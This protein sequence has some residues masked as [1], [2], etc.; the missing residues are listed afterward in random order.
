MTELNRLLLAVA[1]SP[2]SLAAARAAVALAA[3]L[4]AELRVVHVVPDGALR[5]LLAGTQRPPGPAG[6]R[7]AEPVPVLRHVAGLA[8]RAGVPVTTV[9]H[10]GDVGA[11]ILEEARHWGAELIVVGRTTRH[12]AGD[13]FIGVE[14]Q[15]V[16]EFSDCPVLV[17]PGSH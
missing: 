2:A 5:E 12:G 10:E 17:V 11:C 6:E 16:L 9:R 1:D 14:A 13:P 4:G 7:G 15:R 3:R 8:Q